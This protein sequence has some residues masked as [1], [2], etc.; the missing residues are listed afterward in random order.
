[1]RLPGR[2]VA[3]SSACALSEAARSGSDRRASIIQA[4]QGCGSPMT[5]GV[6]LPANTCER[7]RSHA[8]AC[9]YSKLVMASSAS[10]ELA[11]SSWMTALSHW[12][13]RQKSRNSFMRADA[14]VGAALTA[15]SAPASKSGTGSI[16]TPSVCPVHR[17]PDQRR[18]D[19]P[20]RAVP[21]TQ[22]KL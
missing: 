13:V 22:L 10:I 9:L 3:A 8:M 14:L 21:A 1:L 15:L 11:V 12:P 20:H 6:R 4:S 16:A 2:A 5:T 18:R 19:A 17:Q 7:K